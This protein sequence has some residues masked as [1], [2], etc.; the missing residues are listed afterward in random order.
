MT[1]HYQHPPKLAVRGRY[2][3]LLDFAGHGRYRNPAP[4]RDEP[5]VCS[6]GYTYLLEPASTVSKPI[7]TFDARIDPAILQTNIVSDDFEFLRLKNNQRGNRSTT[8]ASLGKLPSPPPL[9]GNI[10]AHKLIHTSPEA[11]RSGGRAYQP[12]RRT[13]DGRVILGHTQ[14]IMPASQTPTV[15]CVWHTEV[16]HPPTVK[17]ETPRRVSSVAIKIILGLCQK[18]R[19]LL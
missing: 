4:R 19:R 7:N 6:N 16:Q 18:L 17:R 15:R 12:N 14:S 5:T 1:M 13:P 8:L 10:N 2:K 3:R 9:A 11:G